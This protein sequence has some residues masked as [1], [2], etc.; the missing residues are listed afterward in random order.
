MRSEGIDLRSYLSTSRAGHERNFS[1]QV[2]LDQV[3][4]AL[5]YVDDLVT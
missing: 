1:V 5:G 4:E 2:R 3:E